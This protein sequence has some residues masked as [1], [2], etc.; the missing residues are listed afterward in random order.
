MQSFSELEQ[1]A[2]KLPKAQRATLACRLLDSLARVLSDE[3]EGVAEALRRDA[4]LEGDPGAGLS[5]EELRQKCHFAL[6][7]PEQPTV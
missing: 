6:P 5:L 1:E 4:E 7:R 2:M 3:D